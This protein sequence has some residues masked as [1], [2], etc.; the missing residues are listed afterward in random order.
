LSKQSHALESTL[1]RIW[2]RR[3]LCALALW[4]LSLLFRAL[5]AVRR[6]LYA[7]GLLKSTRLPVPVI[8]VGNIFIGG[9]GKT[10]FVIWLV[11]A[12]RAVGYTPGV[13]S[14]GHGTD[15]RQIQHVTPTSLPQDSGDEPLLLAQRTHCPIMVG[16]DRAAAGLALLAAYPNVDILISDDGLQH[17][18]L[19][20]DVEIVV[21]DERGTGNGWMLPAGPLR[22]PASRRRDFSVV[23]AAHFPADSENIALMKLSGDFAEKLTDR[24]QRVPLAD[25]PSLLKTS[26]NSSPQLLA[27]AGIGNPERFFSLLSAAGLKFDELPL[28]DHFDYKTSP[29]INKEID[30][31]LITEKD[32]VKCA[33]FE[34]PE[35][36]GKFWVVPVTARIDAALTERILKRCRVGSWFT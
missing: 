3:G 27:A 8:V 7:L 30:I 29:F 32:A 36:L 19:Q 33:V 35:N 6:S 16:R 13:I 26:E 18:A 23:N 12:L 28:P 25:L 1:K 4:P 5:V 14:R 31:I 10:P 9:T 17:Y 2:M 15:S 11:E 20:R 34:T 21:S 22:E 24:S